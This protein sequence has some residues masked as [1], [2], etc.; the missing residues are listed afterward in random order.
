MRRLSACRHP[1][2]ESSRR[3][4]P[5]GT[6]RPRKVHRQATL[7]ENFPTNKFGNKIYFEVAADEQSFVPG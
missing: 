5:C 7:V 6:Q 2:P 3:E 4:S 1:D